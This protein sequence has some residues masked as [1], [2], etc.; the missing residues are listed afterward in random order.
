MIVGAGRTV[1]ALACD[2]R[3]RGVDAQVVDRLDEPAAT[4]RALGLQ[5][6]GRQI[7]DRLGA[8]GDLPKEAPPH[9]EF[10]VYVDGRHRLR[11]DLDALGIATITVRFACLRRRSNAAFVNGCENWGS[12]RI[13]ATK[14]S[15]LVKTLMGS[16]SRSARRTAL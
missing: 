3:S 2:L 5:P 8:L 4:T 11:V 12:R 10:D 16:Q 15:T 7:L 13:G 14:S 1:L 9:T 6:R